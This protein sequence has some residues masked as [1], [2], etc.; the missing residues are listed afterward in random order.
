MPNRMRLWQ[1]EITERILAFPSQG[2]VRLGR[3]CLL[4]RSALI[5]FVALWLDVQLHHWVYFPYVGMEHA[6]CEKTMQIF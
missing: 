4:C 3:Y 5:E 1:S 6:E 2:E